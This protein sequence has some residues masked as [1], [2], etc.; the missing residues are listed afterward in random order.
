MFGR[1]HLGILTHPGYNDLGKSD[2]PPA[3]DYAG[4]AQATA[5]GN[6]DAAR[7]AAKANRVSQYTP[8]GSLVYTRSPEDQDVWS[9]T[10]SLS[11][12]QQA[13]LDQ[14][15]KISLG[16]G[17]TMN[18]GL[19]YVQNVLDTPFDT[20]ALPTSISPD[21]AGREAISQALME[22]QQPQFD[23]R[24]QATEADLLA[25][26]FN[27]GGQGWTGRM[28]DLARA[29]NDARMAA[30]IAGGQEQAR[31]FSL[32][33]QGR[34]QAL[35]EQAFLRN[36]PINTLNAVRTGAQV[37]NPQFTAVPQQQTTAGPN[38]LGAAQAQYGG[39][40]DAYNA[41]QAQNAGLTSGLFGLGNAALM[42][43][44]GTFSD[45]RLKRN[46]K[47]IGTHR[48]G[49]GIY[50]FDYVWGE[51]AVGV[52]ADEVR[53]VRP[54]AVTTVGGYDMVDYGAL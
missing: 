6:L 44:V 10:V 32:G 30:T 11:P 21:V 51:H 48:I 33:Q 8:Y 25:R 50:E 7:V 26:G 29:E 40:L 35:Q 28:D 36:E 18:Q 43:P 49:I 27:P 4:A 2:P 17:S 15:N 19:G 45:R 42:A 5:A 46:I 38:L 20:S 23:I 37:T 34:Q 14:Q 47:R 52:M 1:K 9:S 54:D 16:L 22:R 24:R 3:P 53:K 39:A 31:L 13:L 41:Q 12:E